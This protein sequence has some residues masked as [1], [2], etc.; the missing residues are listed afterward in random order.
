MLPPIFASLSV[1]S[2]SIVVI[3]EAPRSGFVLDSP[4]ISTPST[5]RS[6]RC[7][8]A[9]LSAANFP[10]VALASSIHLI[11]SRSRTSTCGVT[12]IVF[13]RSECSSRCEE[14]QRS[15]SKFQ[16]RLSRS[17]QHVRLTTPAPAPRPLDGCTR[18]CAE[19]D[20]LPVRTA[21]L[22]FRSTKS[23]R[24]RVRPSQPSQLTR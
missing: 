12:G 3:A 18:H 8:R 4:S 22:H 5:T 6:A 1:T 7:I 14:E 19:S 11:R 9:P 15:E 24:R 13:V 20:A 16:L 21:L 10:E 23:D 2:R 17:R